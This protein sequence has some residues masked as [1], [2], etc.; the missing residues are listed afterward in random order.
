M[1]I[2]RASKRALRDARM[3]GFLGAI[4]IVFR[5]NMKP[6]TIKL[7]IGEI[8]CAELMPDSLTIPPGWSDKE[9]KDFLCFVSAPGS[10]FPIIGF[11]RDEVVATKFMNIL[12]RSITLFLEVV[13]PEEL[14]T[15]KTS[16]CTAR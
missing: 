12:P 16:S 13:L 3:R 10:C 2:D 14:I 1:K 8:K 15:V 5:R 11:V 4:P 6:D 7:V 9:I